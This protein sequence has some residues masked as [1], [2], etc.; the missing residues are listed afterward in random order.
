MATLTAFFTCSL[1]LRITDASGGFDWAEPPD[2]VHA[3][4][5]DR[6]RP[7]GTYLYGRRMWETMRFW[8]TMPV[9]DG[10]MGDFGALWREAD[11]VVYSRTLDAAGTARTRIERRFDAADVRSLKDAATAPLTV[12]GAELAGEALI[13]GVVD[14]LELLVV[15]V[16][17]GEGPRALP[18][19]LGTV[20]ELLEQRA[21]PAG[22][23][24][25]RYAVRGAV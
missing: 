25:L 19:G 12:G 18:D 23:M 14:E 15:P 3:F 2:D 6:T 8:E 11:K 20:L 16:I 1:D 21:F 13:A 9:E 10:V 5:N 17:V 4:V 22:W 24:H 7:V